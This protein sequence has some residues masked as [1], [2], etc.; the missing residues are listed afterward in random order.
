MQLKVDVR[1]KGVGYFFGGTRKKPIVSV[2]CPKC[3][4]AAIVS[5][6]SKAGGY[7]TTEYAHTFVIA[8]NAKHEPELTYGTLHTLSDA[9]E[10][11]KHACMWPACDMQIA[12]R[13]AFCFKHWFRMPKW[14]RDKIAAAYVPGQKL[15]SDIAAVMFKWIGNSK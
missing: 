11:V 4:Q 6:E 8:P 14:L 7:N 13:W 5:K 3:N 12:T 15:R 1:T 9:P 2:E 10:E